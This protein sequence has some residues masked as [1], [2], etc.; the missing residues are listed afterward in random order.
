[1][2][3]RVM[4]ILSC[5]F[6]SIGFIF[7]QTTKISGTV[8][9]NNGESVIGASVVVK[10]TT[11]GVATDLDGKFTIEVPDGKNT[12]V[13]S[14]VGMNTIEHA[15]KQGMKVVMNDKETALDEVMVVAYGT[16][17]KSQFTG[18]AGVIKSEN[19][20]KKQTSNVTNALAGQVSGV[21]VLS[22]NGQP[23]ST[24]SI[25]I[26]GTGSISASNAPLYVVDGIPYDGDIASISNA[27]VESMTVLK[28]AASNALYGARG[29]NGVIL[30]TT[31]SG[32]LGG[33]A[34]DAV[35]TVDA[36]W[37]TNRKATPNY[38]VFTSPAGYY[39][40]AYEALYNSQLLNKGLS[41]DAA[42][43]YALSTI[44]SKSNGGLGYKVY[45][46]PTG[47]DFILKG[48][49]INP[50]ATLG[51]TEGNFYYTPDNWYDEMF[52]N[53]NLRQEYNISISGASE[54]ISYYLSGSY[55]D[56]T[57]I[58]PN[59][60]FERFSTRLKAD[61]Q[62][63]KWLKIG[64]NLSY[65]NYNSKSPANQTSSGSSANIFYVANLMAPIYPL[66]VRNTDG[67]IR[68]DDRGLTVYDFGNNTGFTRSFMNQSNPG[69]DLELD[70]RNNRADIFSGRWTADANIYDGLRAK[71]SFGYDI[72]NTQYKRLYNA[73][74]G[75]YAPGGGI[76]YVGS[77]KTI[78][79]NLQYLL[80]Y[81][82]SLGN[83]NIDVL[84]GY[85]TYK[86]KYSSLLG[87]KKKLYNPEIIEL[88]NAINEPTA[89][90][91]TVSYATESFLG[92]IQYDYAG[93]YFGS[94]SLRRDGSSRFHKDNRWGNFWSIGGAWL[95]SKR[96]ISNVEWIN[97]LKFKASFGQQGNDALLY[98]DGTAN[99]YPYQNQYEIVNNNG[100]F[101]TPMFY[102]GNSDITW[103]TSN[104]FNTGLDFE[105]FNSKLS[106][107][108]EYFLRKT[109][110]Q[111]YF[112]P[113]PTSSGYAFHP[114][115]IGSVSNS[116]LELDLSYNIVDNKVLHWSVSANATFI[117]NKINE[118]DP[119]LTNGYFLDGSRIYEEGKSMYRY[120]F[121]KYAGVNKETGESLW[122][123]DIVEDGKVVG[124]ETT[125]NYQA[126][127]KY[128][129]EDLL[130]PIYGGFGTNLAYKGFDLSISFAYQ[131]GGKVYD[132]TYASLMHTGTSSSAGQ[133]WHKDILKSWNS[134]NTNSNIP[135]VSSG[136]TYTNRSSTRF[137]TDASYLSINNI[138]LGYTIPKSLLGKID[139]SSVRIYGVVDNV[140]L[141]S[142]RKGMDPRQSLT[143]VGN[144]NYSP[145]RSISGGITVT[146]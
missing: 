45:N 71:V 28:D 61:Y 34:R 117:K 112:R 32:S 78:S 93:E 20:I 13:F 51:Y 96:V 47:E 132:N 138:N 113:I 69:S 6:I 55:L 44:T 63:K 108:V 115:N 15:A 24:P 105:L 50:N 99:Y 134:E 146:F 107:T 98:E 135:R 120:Y 39:E 40:K 102:L 128:G 59:S 125:N 43:T 145:I 33:T 97:M 16:A 129:T 104:S 84:A 89:T 67:T 124:K 133:N 118:L 26:R 52:D 7:A 76:A 111:L 88:N 27:D 136:D 92:R 140:A 19:I 114:M 144:Y 95:L 18:S 122:Y 131:I 31:K 23:G 79:R 130:A 58:I 119:S 65:T 29:A 137:L 30:I 90:S 70:K 141:F 5:L 37:G 4:L 139:L 106:G 11:I 56:D 25:R 87:S 36:K 126:A 9:D 54:K 143:G 73:Y 86:Y 121:P 127:T 46:V 62:A 81:N 103:E 12:L 100:E 1:M 72:D 109:T 64:T 75:Q 42:H 21:Q 142:K 74:Y 53:G 38:D 82:K 57:G 8:V 83:H 91:S 49:K 60:G 80:T 110:D 94:A 101:A 123:K 22:S 3:K 66:Y 10:G 35:I 77:Y 85:E 14:L 2:K 68:V 17:K 116:G 41:A 48:G